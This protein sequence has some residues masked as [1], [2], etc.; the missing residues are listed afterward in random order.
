M[1]AI[2]TNDFRLRAAEQFIAD[3]S[4]EAK[5]YLGVGYPQE[6]DNDTSPDTPLDIDHFTKRTIWHNMLAM[7]KLQATDI[8]YA[9]PRY[10]W[11]SGTTYSEYDDRD[12]NLEG[13]AYY[14]ISD[15]N[16]VYLCLK[17][18]PGA[19][20]R[21]PDIEGVQT[22]GV[23]DF[24]A[25]DGYIWKYMF[26]ISANAT[27]QFL[28]SSFFPVSFLTEDPGGESDTALQNQYAV[29]QNA[30]DGAIY[31]LK[32][33]NGGTGYTSATVTIE[34][35]GTG[36]TATAVIA[37]GIITGINMTNY[38][39]GYN[40]ATVTIQGD[41]TSAAA[42]A[43]IGPKG[44]FGADPRKDLRAHYVTINARLTGTEGGDFPVNNDFRQISLIRDPLTSTG[45]DVV[46][47]ADTLSVCK[48]LSVATG[49][50]WAADDIIEGDDSGALG[51]VVDYDAVNGVLRYIQNE[52]T[53]FTEFTTNDTIF[54][55]GTNTNGSA[56][57]SVDDGEVLF[58]TGQTM[59]LENRTPINRQDDQIETIKLVIAL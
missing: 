31:N 53:G 46:A 50:S 36:A 20:N 38:G 30:V 26:T 27:T 39:S 15:N 45:P 5:Y 14:V 35:D 49:G 57:S 10:Q 11:I 7:K 40:Y 6:W 47:T 44:G 55:E 28:T 32:V 13:K 1:T 56:V 51:V 58:Y 9:V 19:S 3:I 52:S 34:G 24:S 21:N 22:S 59:F 16:N 25:N 12:G 2:I 29:Q 37:G 43:V 33:T 41:G 8:T 42:R 54:I 17:A 48:S 23:I 18:G 4:E